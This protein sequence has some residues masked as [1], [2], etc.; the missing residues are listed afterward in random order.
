[1]EDS[2]PILSPAQRAE[3]IWLNGK[4]GIS[5]YTSHRL[6][7][8]GLATSKINDFLQSTVGIWPD[9]CLTNNTNM[10]TIEQL[11]AAHAKVTT[12]AEFPNY[13][14]EIIMLG[15]TAYETFVADGNTAY[16]GKDGYT[17]ASG[18]KYE[19]L[20]IASLGN[21]EPFK[22]ALKA[23]QQGKTG[24]QTFCRNCAEFGVEKWMVDT[25][26]MTCSYHDRAGN[27]MLVEV[28]PA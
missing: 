3:S 17:V 21:E 6:A 26:A 11:E 27:D 23:H 10:F 4:Q 24:F 13:I 7:A 18:P 12:G 14:Q 2:I 28:I 9:I 15:V 22:R 5:I 8:A 20:T 25:A 19:A 1:M 16:H